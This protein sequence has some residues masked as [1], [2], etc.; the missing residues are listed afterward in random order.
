MLS[1]GKKQ[2][3]AFSIQG[4]CPELYLHSN[5]ALENVCLPDDVDTYH[6]AVKHIA[7]KVPVLIGELFIGAVKWMNSR[8][9]IK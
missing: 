8:T 6:R 2:G 5:T 9:I 3:T 4:L 1:L 7:Q